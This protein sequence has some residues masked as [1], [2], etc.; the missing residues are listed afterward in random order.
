MRFDFGSQK[1]SNEKIGFKLK[2]S[3]NCLPRFCFTP[4]MSQGCRE[5]AITRRK[6]RVF[7]EGFIGCLDRLVEAPKPNERDPN[8]RERRV[9]QWIEWAQ[10][11]SAFKTADCFLVLPRIPVRPASQVPCKGRIWIKRNRTVHH[12]G[13]SFEIAGQG[14]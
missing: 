8:S 4:K 11:N 2:L 14:H 12:F 9:K 13:R 5:T 6:G 1:F 7:A 3:G 10:A